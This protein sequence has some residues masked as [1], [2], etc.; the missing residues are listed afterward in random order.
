MDRIQKAVDE[1][2]RH[3]YPL[4]V[5]D[6]TKPEMKLLIWVLNIDNTEDFLPRLPEAE[7][8]KHAIATL[9]QVMRKHSLVLHVVSKDRNRARVLCGPHSDLNPFVVH[10]IFELLDVE[11]VEHLWKLDRYIDLL[12]PSICEIVR[13]LQAM[14]GMWWLPDDQVVPGPDNIIYQRNRCEACILARVVDEPMYLQNL[15]TALLARSKLKRAPRLLSFVEEAMNT[16]GNVTATLFYMSGQLAFDMKAARKEADDQW[17]MSKSREEIEALGAL[18]KKREKELQEM[19]RRNIDSKLQEIRVYMDPESEEGQEVLR[20][21]SARSSDGAGFAGRPEDGAHDDPLVDEISAAHAALSTADDEL[22]LVR[23]AY[24]ESR[25]TATSSESSASV[26]GASELAVAPVA[27]LV[28]QKDKPLPPLPRK[29]LP[30]DSDFSSGGPG[31][32]STADK[33]KGRVSN[34]TEAKQR[35]LSIWRWNMPTSSIVLGAKV[36]T[37]MT[38]CSAH[39]RL[40]TPRP[41]MKMLR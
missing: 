40:D 23:E 39:R 15:R 33:G 11:I 8:I 22:P 12:E 26:C 24:P 31:T 9:P 41:S 29:P 28:I 2:V 10:H 13:E 38:T 36:R 7:R 3:R 30:M 35:A 4:M 5:S 17:R 34:A 25:F 14:R 20:A 27:P 19:Q 21:E 32:P 6:L 18:A 37:N 16:H 1:H